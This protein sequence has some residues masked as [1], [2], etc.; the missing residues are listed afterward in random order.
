MK[1][2]DAGKQYIHEIKKVLP[3]NSTQK[4]RYIASLR[5]SI[6]MYLLEHPDATLDDLYSAFGAPN[7]IVADYLYNADAMDISKKISKKKLLIVGLVIIAVIAAVSIG[8]AVRVS[9]DVHDIKHG[10]FVDEVHVYPEDTESIPNEFD[11]Y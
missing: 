3:C 8:V 7:S 4:K 6:Q 11:S 1:S 2:N 10:F 5:D 9:S